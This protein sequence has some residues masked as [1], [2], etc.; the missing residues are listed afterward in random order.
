VRA[1]TPADR[2]D[3]AREYFDSA[4]V[5]I[6]VVGDRTQIEEQAHLFGDTEIFDAQ[7]KHLS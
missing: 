1:R 6:V 4:N 5:Q 3:T 7:G 2:G